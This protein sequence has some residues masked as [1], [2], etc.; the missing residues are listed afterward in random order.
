[1]LH[2]ASWAFWN[3]RGSFL[4]LRV[5]AKACNI[6]RQVPQENFLAVSVKMAVVLVVGV[7]IVRALPFGVYI[8]ALDSRKLPRVFVPCGSVL[9]AKTAL[10]LC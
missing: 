4:K 7:L 6:V 3:L 8:T 1:M 9:T 2:L 5:L 10:M